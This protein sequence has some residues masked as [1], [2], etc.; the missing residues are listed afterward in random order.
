MAY[1]SYK[2]A[3]LEALKS[4]IDRA[5]DDIGDR[6]AGH[7]QDHATV[8]TGNMRA[9][10]I[11]EREGEATEVIGPSDSAAP[12]KPVGYAKYVEL[13]TQ[14]Q[15]PQPFLRPAAENYFSEYVA[16]LRDELNS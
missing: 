2:D 5:M 13:G 10:I 11:H 6:C 16:I 4:A 14:R 1:K 12:Y 9:S 15:S 3:V 7:A 8:D